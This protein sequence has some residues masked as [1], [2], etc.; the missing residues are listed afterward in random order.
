MAAQRADRGHSRYAARRRAPPRV[1]G[2]THTMRSDHLIAVSALVSWYN[3]SFVS[4]ILY[5]LI[6]KLINFI[7]PKLDINY[8]KYGNVDT[9]EIYFT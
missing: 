8:V 6:I 3:D 2:D 1:A 7:K 5:L 4:I 9:T